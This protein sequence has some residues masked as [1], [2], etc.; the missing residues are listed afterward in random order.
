LVGA[1]LG[2]AEVLGNLDEA[3]QL[4]AR[5]D[6]TLAKGTEANRALGILFRTWRRGGV[7]Q[8]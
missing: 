8:R 7:D 1:L 6:K 5:H 3:E 2:D 4:A